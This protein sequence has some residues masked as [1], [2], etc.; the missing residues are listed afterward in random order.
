MKTTDLRKLNHAIAVADTRSYARASERLH[1]T[2]SALSRSI[3]AL[4]QE[5]G[6]KLFDR[7][8]SGVRVTVD[9]SKVLTKARQLLFEERTFERE[10]K[11]LKQ[12][13][14]DDIAFGV[15]PAMPCLFLP[16]LLSNVTE[17]HP[18]LSL[19]VA[20]ESGERLL[21]LLREETIEFF[22]A[23]TRQFTG[24]DDRIFT[25]EPL[26]DIAAGFYAR[27]Q[28]PLANQRNINSDQLGDFPLVSPQHRKA[29]VS[30]TIASPQ[31][32]NNSAAPVQIH[33]ND[34][35]TLRKLVADTDAILIGIEPMVKQQLHTGSIKAL[36]MQGI[37]PKPMCSI[38]LVTLAGRTPSMAAS[39]ICAQL[40]RLLES[41][42]SR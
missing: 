10:I 3:Q 20:I 5:L 4:E 16:E 31:S 36:D 39:L 12:A 9:G 18:A 29:A 1:L 14:S 37:D 11:L 40:R 41:K 25:S 38:A 27:R 26:V 22:V 30:S 13:E 23:D 24:L 42:P 21:E 28:H 35:D 34:L 8:K 15:G 6:L 32:S 33:C 7:D 2:Q 17:K 19:D